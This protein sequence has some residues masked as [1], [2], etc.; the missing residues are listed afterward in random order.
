MGQLT[1]KV[2]G[3]LTSLL[4]S[5]LL[6]PH[7]HRLHRYKKLDTLLFKSLGS[8]FFSLNLSNKTVKIFIMSEMFSISNKCLFMFF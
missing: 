2:E 1:T 5:S 4:H 8:F 7:Q 3:F 6:I